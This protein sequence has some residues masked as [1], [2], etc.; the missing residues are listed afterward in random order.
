M[1]EEFNRKQNDDE[2]LMI[3]F[4]ARKKFDLSNFICY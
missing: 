2:M 3:Q 4:Y 1:W